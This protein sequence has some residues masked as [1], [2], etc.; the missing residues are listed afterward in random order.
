ME[1]SMTS[2]CFTVW[3]VWV[4]ALPLLAACGGSYYQVTD[5][6]SGKSY[7]TRDIDRD[8]GRARF[9]DNASG[10]KVNLDSFEVRKIT[11]QQYRNAVRK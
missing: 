9:K 11:E 2:R 10:D 1:K 4:I 3:A 7:Y 5:T 6:S 8:D